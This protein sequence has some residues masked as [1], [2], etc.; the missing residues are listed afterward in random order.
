MLFNEVCLLF[1]LLNGTGDIIGIDYGMAFGMATSQLPVP[2]VVPCRLTAQFQFLIPGL[3]LNGS[4]RDSMVHTLRVAKAESGSII[5]A[6][7]VFVT[8]PTLNW[9]KE[10]EKKTENR[11]Q[12][13]FT[14]ESTNWSPTQIVERTDNLL[15]GFHP[16]VITCQDLQENKIFLTAD[17][18]KLLPQLIAVVRGNRSMLTSLETIK[19]KVEP[20]SSRRAS[21]PQQGLSSEQQVSGSQFFLINRL[22]QPKINSFYV[23]CRSNA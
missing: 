23:P 10:A 11:F 12:A 6:L 21:M 13:T 22:I 16:S 2:E 19:R 4:V 14:K 1:S 7:S 18:Q 3:S 17:G 5:A 9:L 20:H 8:E 15:N